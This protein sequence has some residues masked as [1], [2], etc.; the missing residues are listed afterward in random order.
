MTPKNPKLKFGPWD[1]TTVGSRCWGILWRCNARLHRKSESILEGLFRGRKRGEISACTDPQELAKPRIYQHREVLPVSQ[2]RRSSMTSSKTGEIHE[3]VPVVHVTCKAS[4]DV[5]IS[6]KSISP[7]ENTPRSDD[8]LL[9]V[10]TPEETMSSKNFPRKMT[11]IR[12]DPLRGSEEQ[13]KQRPSVH[14]ATKRHQVQQELFQTC[15]A[16]V[17]DP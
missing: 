1:D 15:S 13:A 4:D 6:L 12:L 2:V 8:A 5:L 9:G 17:R 14:L 16:S 11:D 7:L 10:A 3:H